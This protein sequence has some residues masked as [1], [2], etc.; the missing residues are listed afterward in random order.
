MRRLAPREP[1]PPIAPVPG[2]SDRRGRPAIGGLRQKYWSKPGAGASDFSR[3][4][5]ECA[6]ENAVQVS[7]SKDYGI[8]I[9][10]LYKVCL[11]SRG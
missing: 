4:S 9:A 5:N 11:K 3:E 1:S 8:V 7:A 6:R 10:D 2:C